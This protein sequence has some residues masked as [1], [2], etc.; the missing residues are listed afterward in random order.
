MIIWR[1]QHR[2]DGTRDESKNGGGMRDKNTSVGTGFAYFQTSRER[3]S[4]NIDGD[5]ECKTENNRF[6]MLR[7]FQVGRDGGI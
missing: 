3:G 6:P 4:F 2:F 1:V 7:V 5:A